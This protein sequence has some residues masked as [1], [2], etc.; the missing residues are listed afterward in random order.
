MST[1]KI[2]MLVVHGM[3]AQQPG[4][5]EG[6][7]SEI[8]DRLGNDAARFDW[9]EVYW[10]DAL[11]NRETKL[12][13][14]MT[15]AK[16]PDG[17]ELEL[18]WTKVRDFVLHNFGDALA[19]HRDI[20]ANGAYN[21]IHTIVHQHIAALKGRLPSVTCPVVVMAHSLGA[22]IMSNYIWDHQPPNP[23]ADGLEPLPTLAAIITFGC[24]IP[25]FSLTFPAA[26]P[27][28]VPGAGIVKPELIEA[29]R[30]L[31]FVDPDDVLGWP[32]GPLYANSQATGTFTSE[33]KRTVAKIEDYAISVGNLITSWNPAAHGD[34]WEDNDFTK[35]VAAY[36]KRLLEAVDA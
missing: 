11:E 21:D 3:G 34:Y 6:M 27:I 8:N 29:S 28:D 22:H 17:T 33:E 26:K 4:F 15:S 10:A 23:V 9:E 31:N 2:G 19:Y 32:L 20:Q 36:L 24:N 1:D 18:E 7:K 5:A 13:E 12:W 25:L 35:P 30:W 14:D 16:Q